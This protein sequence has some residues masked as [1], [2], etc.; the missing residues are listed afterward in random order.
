MTDDERTAYYK[1][2]FTEETRSHIVQCLRAGK[3][4]PAKETSALVETVMLL[5]AQRQIDQETIR[6]LCLVILE[7]TEHFVPL[8]RNNGWITEAEQ[9]KTLPRRN[10][11]TLG[12]S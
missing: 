8:C 3:G 6:G 2:L 1:A 10:R 9:A 11:A 5:S 12:E 7:M 4:L